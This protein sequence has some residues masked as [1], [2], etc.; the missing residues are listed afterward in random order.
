MDNWVFIDRL[1]NYLEDISLINLSK[2]CKLLYNYLNDTTI[3][4]RRCKRYNIKRDYDDGDWKETYILYRPIFVNPS[5]TVFCESYQDNN[6]IPEER[7]LY[8]ITDLNIEYYCVETD[9]DEIKI[10]RITLVKLYRDNLGNKYYKYNEIASYFV[11]LAW[12]S[13]KEE[14]VWRMKIDIISFSWTTSERFKY[15]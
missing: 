14:H 9:Y 15:L 1:S 7:V 13:N 6:V 3:W 4:K 5:K 11:V 12:D 2:T 10:D 8:K